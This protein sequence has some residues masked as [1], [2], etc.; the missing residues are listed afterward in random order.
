M[1]AALWMDPRL[2]LRRSAD[3]DTVILILN[4]TQIAHGSFAEQSNRF[5]WVD[6]RNAHSTVMTGGTPQG[7]PLSPAL[8]TIYISELIRKA[9]LKLQS[10]HQ[11]A[12]AS[13]R[14]RPVSM[15]KEEV[16]PLL[17][18]DDVNT[19]IPRS[20]KT[21]RW[22]D[23]LNEAGDS[24]KLEWDKSK[25]WEGRD[26]KHLGIYLNNERKHWKERVR[27][28]E[29]YGHACGGWQ[30]FHRKPKEL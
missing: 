28:A 12:R 22:Y 13:L 26:G 27:K 16:L 2:H 23:Y 7:S 20:L 1:C 15:K 5:V 8:F 4:L 17:Y 19:I 25:D 10:Q 9:E 18:I 29:G 3:I 21:A 24:M 30:G 11:A 14:A 6:G